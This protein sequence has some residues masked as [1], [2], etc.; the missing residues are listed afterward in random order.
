MDIDKKCQSPKI[1]KTQESTIVNHKIRKKKPP[2]NEFLD[3][4]AQISS[5]ECSGDELSDDS[6]GSIVDF[7][8]DDEENVVKEDM[9]ALYLESV[10][11]PVK[12]MFKI[13]QLP[14]K[15]KNADILSQY[16][17]EDAY[18]MDSFCVDSHIGLTQ[19]HDD[20]ELELAEQILEM[21][22]KRRRKPKPKNTKLDDKTKDTPSVELLSQSGDSP[23]IKRRQM[24]VARRI[25]SDSDDS[26]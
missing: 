9:H 2:R 13:P 25:S 20:S 21:K 7:I 11:S 3:L 12:G 16:V 24:K 19:V 26:G 5:D 6:V 23:V 15:Y 18:E 8:C 14:S 17:E 10:K 4:S 22:R 1:K